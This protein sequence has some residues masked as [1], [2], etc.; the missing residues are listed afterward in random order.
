MR[1]RKFLG[2]ASVAIALVTA[3]TDVALAA[4]AKKAA[5]PIDLI[6]VPA[7]PEGRASAPQGGTFYYNMEG[8]PPTLNP[9]TSTDLYSKWIF[10]FTTDKLLRR[11]ED[12]YA[13]GPGLAESAQATPDGKTYTFKLRKDAKWWDGKPVTA[14]DVKFSFDAIFD[15]TYHAAQLRPYFDTFEKCEIVDPLTVRFVAKEK[16]FANV[17][18]LGDTLRILPKHVYGNAAEGVKLNKSFVGSGPYKVEKWDQGQRITLVRNKDWWG[19]SAPW[20]KGA[21]NFDRVVFRFVKEETVMLEM[22]KKGDLDY[23]NRLSPEAFV[24]KAVGPEWGTKVLKI[25]TENKEPKEYGYVGW[26]MHKPMFAD[27]DVRVALQSLMNREEMIKKFRY[28]M[29]VPA[30]GPWYLQ[31]EYA[32]PARKAIAFNPMKARELFAKAG[33]KDTDGDGILDKTVDGKKTNFEFTLIHGSKDAEKYLTMFQEDLKKAGVRMNIQLFEWNA[34]M[35]AKDDR[36]FDAMAMAWGGGDVDFDPKQIWH[37][38]SDAKGG[39][40]YVGYKNAEV[41]KL[42]D[43]ARQEL[44]KPKRVKMLRKIYDLIADDAP[45]A[46]MFNSRYA[47][48]A[49]AARIGAARDTLGFGKGE[50]MW[51]DA[52]L[53]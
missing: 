23:I 21:F 50:A 46:F 49:R 10:D 26:N 25:K 31:S 44:D 12:T 34:M 39:S 27:R 37:S 28:G 40:N 6:V 17:D 8:E 20:L 42:I 52:A 2:G 36:S 41:D 38:S 51:W 48:Y 47:L 7:K 1:N 18:V 43:Q 35:K 13:Y 16:Y 32:D 11:S 5:A 14:D 19:N 45:Y 3:M 22:I 24:K 53:K 29:S 9:L 33:W 30:T 4:K 15:D